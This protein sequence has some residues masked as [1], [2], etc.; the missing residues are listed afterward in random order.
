MDTMT[1]LVAVVV[2]VVVVVTVIYM[3]K[4]AYMK[5]GSTVYPRFSG[6]I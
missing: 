3:E 4:T 2:V 6:L 1:M 5:V